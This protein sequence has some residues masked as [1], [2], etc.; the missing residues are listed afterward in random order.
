MMYKMGRGS[1]IEEFWHSDYGIPLFCATMSR[2]RF[3]TILR[4]FRFDD[5][6]TKDLEEKKGE[7]EA[8]VMQET[9]DLFV[10]QCK[11]SFMPSSNITVDLCS[12][13]GICSFKVYIPSKPRK[14][15]IKIWCAVDCKHVYL[16]NLQNYTVQGGDVRDLCVASGSE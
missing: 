7:N 9:L 4:Y 15:G 13:R 3:Q 16:V 1:L 12:Y 2:V 6:N 10:V 14:Y 11:T 5:G 8:E